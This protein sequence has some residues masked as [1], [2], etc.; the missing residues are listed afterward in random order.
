[1]L[2]DLELYQYIK[3]AD[4][5]PD[6]HI[7]CVTPDR[8]WLND[9]RVG[10]SNLILT[11]TT[12][13]TL[14]HLKDLYNSIA[15]AHTV[16]SDCELI[17]IDMRGVIIKLS[18]DMNT[19]ATFIGRVDDLWMPQCVYCS[20]FT[21]DLLVG[22]LREDVEAAKVMRYNQTGQLSQTIQHDNT[23]LELY[24]KPVFVIENN[25]GDVVVSDFNFMP[26]AIVVTG[27]GG[28]HRFSYTGHPPELGIQPC[29]ICTDALSNILVLDAINKTVDIIDERGQF[30][31]HLQTKSNKIRHITSFGYDVNTHRLLVG[32]FHASRNVCVYNYPT[33]QDNLTGMHVN[34]N[35][36]VSF[37]NVT[38][39]I[40]LLIN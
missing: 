39:Y 11:N 32:I 15:G 16:N 1:M 3:V 19:F 30:L 21:G 17:Y 33:R 8:A 31:S 35:N 34:S 20:P 4:V 22:M 14:F 38:T 6:N 40:L 24:R 5:R 10:I 27:R 36:T 29:S 2:P 9:C 13:E 7:F 37:I 28:E 26:G 18:K 12:G 25:N 23:G